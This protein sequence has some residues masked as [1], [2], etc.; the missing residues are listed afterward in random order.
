MKL[1]IR[2]CMGRK[3]PK[4]CIMIIRNFRVHIQAEQVIGFF[5]Q[6]RKIHVLSNR[7]DVMATEIFFYQCMCFK[8]KWKSPK[9]PN[10]TV[11]TTLHPFYIL[12]WIFLHKCKHMWYV[13][14]ICKN[15][16]C[17]NKLSCVVYEKKALDLNFRKKAYR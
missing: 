3:N 14:E 4:M 11:I 1:L 15:S 13:F 17:L 8:K 10:T 12:N 16:K 6:N 9:I 5:W 7:K 2:P